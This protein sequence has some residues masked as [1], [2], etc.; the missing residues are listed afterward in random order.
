MYLNKLVIGGFNNGDYW[1]SSEADHYKAWRQDFGNG[2]TSGFV[3]D[4]SK[5]AILSVRAIRAF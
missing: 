5:N 4:V 3:V 2:S 1:S